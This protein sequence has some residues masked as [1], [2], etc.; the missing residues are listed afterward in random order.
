MRRSR[1]SLR[2]IRRNNQV[3]PWSEHKVEIAVRKTFLSLQRDSAPAVAITRAVSE[4]VHSSKQS[5]IHI[6]EIQDIV[7]EEL[8][9]AGHYK[10]AEAYILIAPNGR[11]VV[12]W[13]IETAPAVGRRVEAPSAAGSGASMMVVKKADGSNHFWDGIDLRKRIEFA[14]IGLDLCLSNERDRG[15]TAPLGV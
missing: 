7:Q 13:A 6:E 4:R 8:M 9:K 10:V 1:A 11:S 15:G 2:V 14:R 12:I 3:V 5:F